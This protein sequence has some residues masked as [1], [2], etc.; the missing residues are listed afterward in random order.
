MALSSKKILVSD[1]MVRGVSSVLIK[2]KVWK[3]TMTSLT[4]SLIRVLSKK[5]RLSLPGSPSALRVAL[6]KVLT[7]LSKSGITA[8]FNRT[9]DYS[10]TRLV[11][12]SR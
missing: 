1:I 2:R 5:Q 11:H 9:S 8:K 4:S 6:N 7:R 3:G 12:F 10:R